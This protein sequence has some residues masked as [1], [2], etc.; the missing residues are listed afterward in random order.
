[1][2]RTGAPIQGFLRISKNT[3]LNRSNI[4]HPHLIVVFD[5][6]LLSQVPVFDGL[7]EN[8]IVVL[9]TA[10]RPDMF[11]GKA[12]IVYTV[13]A[14]KISI[15]KK[16][17]S[18]S[19]PIVN[20]AMIGALVRVLGGDI[21]IAKEII[22]DEVP[23]KPEAN[24]EAA[25]IAYNSLSEFINPIPFKPVKTT[26]S[27]AL[28]DV[29]ITPF[30]EKPMSLNK[31]G[32]WRLSIPIYVTKPA[33]CGHYCPAGID[34]REFIK[35]AA[36]KNFDGAYDVIYK[37]N[38]FA[39]VC[40]RACDK[41]CEQHCNRASFDE[42]LNI[43]AIEKY[44]GDKALQRT[45]KP[46]DINQ[47]EKIAVLGSGPAC[48]TAA[49]R[50]RQS[51]YAVT[52]FEASGKTGGLMQDLNIEEEL[53][54]KEI[55]KIIAEGVE[56]ILNKKI[57]IDEITDEFTVVLTSDISENKNQELRKNKNG[58]S[59]FNAGETISTEKFVEAIGNGNNTAKAVEALLRNAKQ[60]A[61]VEE[62]P[63]VTKEDLHFQ[64][65]THS[66]KNNN[67]N[68][69][70]DELI[71]IESASAISAEAERCLHCGSCFN[72]GNCYNFCPDALVY[73]DAKDRL[74]IDY[75]IG[76]AHV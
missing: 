37:N 74:R 73:F 39:S 5:E 23:T 58:V 17:G 9:N 21:E 49:L 42:T 44:L 2:E 35:L 45:V 55:Q 27:P 53:L 33:P 40:G 54:D 63:V 70:S 61:T 59:V 67:L 72:C 11:E 65:Y 66:P 1:M 62:E 69:T 18:R 60:K 41:P 31:T 10:N 20:S 4:Y 28:T 26:A 34:V 13:P 76:R 46:A 22:K 57:S 68:F 14:T 3:I 50:L 51:G 8:G 19:L 15:D 36:E 43:S 48:L 7:R 47:K 16:L 71:L 32:S 24:A 6:S 38:P 30:W 52:I 12:G 25:E 64:Y 29:N 75:E 56:I